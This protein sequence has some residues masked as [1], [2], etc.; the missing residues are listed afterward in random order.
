M[1]FKDTQGLDCLIRR[2]DTLDDTIQTNEIIEEK[3]RE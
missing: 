1:E 2:T 3:A